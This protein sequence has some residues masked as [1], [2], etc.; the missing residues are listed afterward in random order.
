MSNVRVRIS[1]SMYI[2]VNFYEASMHFLLKS[3]KD[4]TQSAKRQKPLQCPVSCVKITYWRWFEF[5]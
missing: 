1:F 3:I 4:A 2:Q 5:D